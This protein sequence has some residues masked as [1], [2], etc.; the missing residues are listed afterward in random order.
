MPMCIRWYKCHSFST[1]ILDTSAIFS[2]EN[3]IVQLF[4][5]LSYRNS[6]AHL[7][8]SRKSGKINVILAEQGESAGMTLLQFSATS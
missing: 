8:T 6:C 7:S 2:Y 5:I 3:D 4:I 1:W